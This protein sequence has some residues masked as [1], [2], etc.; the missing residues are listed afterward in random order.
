MSDPKS[1]GTRATG[2]WERSAETPIFKPAKIAERKC[3]IENKGS[4]CIIL[5]IYV[6]L[7][8]VVSTFC[9][10][11]LATECAWPRNPRRVWC[12][13][14]DTILRFRRWSCWPSTRAGW[15]QHLGTSY[16]NSGSRG[17]DYCK[18]ASHEKTKAI[19]YGRYK[20]ANPQLY[21]PGTVRPWIPVEN[22][23]ILTAGNQPSTNLW[24]NSYG[25]ESNHAFSAIGSM[26]K[27]YPSPTAAEFA[28]GRSKRSNTRQRVSLRTTCHRFMLMIK[29]E[30]TSWSGCTQLHEDI[31]FSCG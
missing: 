26:R 11:F 31:G 25:T 21:L 23:A 29:Q 13:F 28:E 16:K 15:F 5:A 8:E 19:M 30:Y 3:L 9:V 7:R 4:L 22:L 10:C 20:P 27:M 6:A 14:D 24:P 12:I 2:T 17:I 18:N 1:C